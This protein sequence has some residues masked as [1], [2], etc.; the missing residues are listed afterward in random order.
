[1]Q[2]LDNEKEQKILPLFR[3]AFRPF[4][5]AASV[6]SVVA[7][8]MWALF[9]SGKLSPVGWMYNNPIWWHGHE[10]L[11]GFTGAIIVG[12]LLTAVQNWTGNPGVRGGKLAFIFGL[13]LVARIAFLIASPHWVWMVIDLLWMPLAAY[14]LAVPI[15]I[16]KQWNNLFFVPLIVLMTALNALYHIN[17]LN[18]GT[19]P[20]FLSTHALSMMTVMVISL[21]VL[22][23]GGRVIPFFTWRG[24]QSEPITRI[25]G[26][27][28]AALIPTW[29]L[30]LNVLL[31][32]PDAISQVSLPVLL[33][34]TALCHL[35]RFMRWRTLSTCRVPLLWLL[36]FAY[37]AM[38]VGL[39][40]LA[41]YHVNGAVSESIA[42][43]VL[44]VGGIGCMILAMIAR[45][46][47]GHTGRNLQ[48]G[49]WI[50][51]AFVTLVLATLTRT[52]M[53]YLW[54][55]LTIQGYV[56]SAILWAVAFV[57]FT[58]VYFPVLTQPRVD[59]RPG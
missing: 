29:L 34:V 56:I 44:T 5:L 36:H 19:L 55:A 57:I 32:V 49:R 42:L 33:T 4:F 25:K 52:L 11:F 15:L 40:L 22:I 31:P 18:A 46:S 17:V 24:T 1:M 59:G 51:L 14:F 39:L 43:H 23:V 37:L 45:V 8:L 2:I 41:L 27:E 3:L 35:V 9:W 28:L 30:L 26:L 50:V 20:P 12:F 7:M 48:V 6:F 53:I 21:I 13:W 10:M 38:V 58:V 16:R 47:L 54:P